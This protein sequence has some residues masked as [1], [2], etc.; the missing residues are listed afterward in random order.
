MPLRIL[1]ETWK[2]RKTNASMDLRSYSE[3]HPCIYARLRDY[4]NIL[5]I[6]RALFRILHAILRGRREKFSVFGDAAV[7]K[8]AKKSVKEGAKISPK[9]IFKKT[10]DKHLSFPYYQGH[11]SLAQLVEQ[12]IRNQQ[13]KSSSLLAGSTRNFSPIL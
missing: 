13:V 3:L 12:L 4:A 1:Q 9:R 8:S 11:A 2:M 10:L 7:Q 6:L 5:L